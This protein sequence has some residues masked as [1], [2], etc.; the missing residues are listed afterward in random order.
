METKS[1]NSFEL[2]KLA[3]IPVLAEYAASYNITV[4]NGEVVA[5]LKRGLGNVVEVLHDG[6]LHHWPLP[7]TKF[8]SAENRE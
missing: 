4:T 7:E 8:V 1:N 5:L 2:F 6:E 3:S